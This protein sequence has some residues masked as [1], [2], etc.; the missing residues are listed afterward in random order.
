MGKSYLK[1][2]LEDFTKYFPHDHAAIVALLKM[3]GNR[4]KNIVRGENGEGNGLEKKIT[5]AMKPYVEDIMHC[6]NAQTLPANHA[7]FAM[8]AEI[9]KKRFEMKWDYFF[10][11]KSPDR[12][13][14]MGAFWILVAQFFS[15]LAKK[16]AIAGKKAE[17][18]TTPVTVKKTAKKTAAKTDRTAKK[19]G[20]T[21]TKRGAKK[22]KR[23]AKKTRG[24]VRR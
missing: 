7:P 14:Q 9:I 6:W 21:T 10:T 1:S 3:K 18:R 12:F 11:T 20:T 22:T 23:G 17:T 24:A 4:L 5:E 19:S 2:L 16:E 15:T 8:I 13:L